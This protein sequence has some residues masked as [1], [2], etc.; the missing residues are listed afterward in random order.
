MIK[1][2]RDFGTATFKHDLNNPPE[3]LREKAD[4][5]KLVK[6]ELESGLFVVEGKEV[7]FV[8]RWIQDKDT[9][10]ILFYLSNRTVQVWFKDGV[11]IIL[12]L[13]SKEG[14]YINT[15]GILKKYSIGSIMHS[16]NAEVLERARQTMALLEKI[17]EV[18][19]K[20]EENPKIINKI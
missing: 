20:Q 9:E 7:A 1:T 5:L 13:K 17:N 3:S 12:E 11:G 8:D 16:R 2:T 15:E 10:T 19:K 14:F 18:K 4:M 6:S